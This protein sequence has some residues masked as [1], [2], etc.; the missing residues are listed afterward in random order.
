LEKFLDLPRRRDMVTRQPA[1]K[2]TALVKIPDGAPGEMGQSMT[3]ILQLLPVQNFLRRI[4]TPGHD[5]GF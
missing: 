5:E 3:Q 2:I 1:R 4:G